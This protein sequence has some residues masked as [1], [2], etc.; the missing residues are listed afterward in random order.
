MYAVRIPFVDGTEPKVVQ[1]LRDKLLMMTRDEV[2][3]YFHILA[4]VGE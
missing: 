3:D 4:R 2:L 1:D